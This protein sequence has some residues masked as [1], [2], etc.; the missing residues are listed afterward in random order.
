MKLKFIASFILFLLSFA[1]LSEEIK[2]KVLFYDMPPYYIREDGG[3]IG[4][5]YFDMMKAIESESNIKF[6]HELLLLP[7]KR[8]V[9]NII[10]K[11]YDVVFGVPPLENYKQYVTFLEPP[12]HHISYVPLVPASD[13]SHYESMNDF[14][15]TYQNKVLQTHLGTSAA[16]IAKEFGKF[17]VED[18]AKNLEDALFRLKRGRSDF[19]VSTDFQFWWELQKTRF[20]GQ[21]R[22]L[23]LSFYETPVHLVLLKQ[24]EGTKV[25][26]ILHRTIKRLHDSGELQRI[27]DDYILPLE[28]PYQ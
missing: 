8:A 21:F 19:S 5:I 24:Y 6:D 22:M 28:K 2:L 15:D 12:L 18:T 11:R 14:I 16:I 23:P 10:Q 27:I 1:L 26:S 17:Y 20:V 13:Q 9:A 3:Q 25:E 7:V 4:G